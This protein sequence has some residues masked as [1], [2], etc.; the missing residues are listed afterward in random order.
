MHRTMQVLII[1]LGLMVVAAIATAL[2]GRWQRSTATEQALGRGLQPGMPLNEA[3]ALLR[4]LEVP[5]TVH[6]SGEGAAVVTYR[7][8]EARESRVS[9]V[10][11]QQLVFDRQ[12]RL[13]EMLTSAHIS[14]P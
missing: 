7:R 11:E 4:R 5:F 12:G 2:A 13:R 14:S 3:T 10:T 6:Y 8:Q 1:L 9:S